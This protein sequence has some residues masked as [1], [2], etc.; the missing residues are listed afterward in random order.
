MFESRLPSIKDNNRLLSNVSIDALQNN[1][2][3]TGSIFTKKEQMTLLCRSVA[4]KNKNVPMDTYP[5]TDNMQEMLIAF[6]NYIPHII[7]ED[8]FKQYREKFDKYYPKFYTDVPCPSCGNII[9]FSIDLEIEFFRRSLLGRVESV[10]E[11]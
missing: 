1:L 7:S 2:T 4:I 5:K 3:Q 11:L 9:K 10:E 6:S 8:F